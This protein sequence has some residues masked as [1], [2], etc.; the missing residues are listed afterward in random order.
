MGVLYP[1]DHHLGDPL[2]VQST[3]FFGGWLFVVWLY[4]QSV[5]ILNVQGYLPGAF[6]LEFVC[7][8]LWQA[9]Q[10]LEVLRGREFHQAPT[11]QLG[12]LWA[13]SADESLLVVEHPLKFVVLERD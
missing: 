6:P 5:R 1:D 7:S 4:E 10:D 3:V 11:D 2:P 12:L 8:D 9:S 13:P